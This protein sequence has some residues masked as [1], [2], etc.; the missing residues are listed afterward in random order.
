MAVS[1]ELADPFA[2]YLGE[3]VLGPVLAY[4]A[5]KGHGP[6]ARAD[7][8]LA[9]QLSW[10]PAVLAV[11]VFA[12]ATWQL[13]IRG[14]LLA[15]VG[16]AIGGPILFNL[17]SPWSAEPQEALV[18]CDGVRPLQA[19]SSSIA[20]VSVFLL[21]P[22]ATLAVRRVWRRSRPAAMPELGP[23]DGMTDHGTAD[24]SVRYDPGAIQLLILLGWLPTGVTAIVTFV[25][26]STLSTFFGAV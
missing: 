8:P 14:A 24:A 3:A 18:C 15:L 7:W 1:I 2:T 26:R 25:P 10:A 5:A 21:V 6:L 11:I 13:G 23:P 9:N 4:D 12:V 22:V 19:F 17:L 16:F 20:G